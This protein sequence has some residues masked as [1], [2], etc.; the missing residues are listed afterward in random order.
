MLCIFKIGTCKSVTIVRFYV[1]ITD[2]CSYHLVYIDYNL[3]HTK[4]GNDT[5][6][7]VHIKQRGRQFVDHI[8][9]LKSWDDIFRFLLIYVRF[10]GSM[11]ISYPWYNNEKIG[12]Q[13]NIENA[14][15]MSSHRNNTECDEGII[16][17]CHQVVSFY[18]F[19]L[20]NTTNMQNQCYIIDAHVRHWGLMCSW[21][22]SAHI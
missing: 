22:I 16:H 20:I 1:R 5:S 3:W 8:Q 18:C 15:H 10:W 13:Q 7:S 19:C 21:Y 14:N 6:K 4:G 9:S 12:I 2:G 11:H 17:G